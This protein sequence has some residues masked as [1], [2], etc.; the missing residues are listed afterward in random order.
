MKRLDL[1]NLFILTENKIRV[2][3]LKYNTNNN[4]IAKIPT[5]ND[6]LFGVSYDYKT[7]LQI[8][9]QH[10]MTVSDTK[11]VSYTK[12]SSFIGFDTKNV[13]PNY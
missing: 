3:D 7:N 12:S 13:V 1:G 4:I 8:Q 2:A 9:E 5:R 6:N 11:K 10:I